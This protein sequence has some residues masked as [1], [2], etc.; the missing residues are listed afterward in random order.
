MPA[1]AGGA[2]VVLDDNVDSWAARMRILESAQ[3]SI[4]VQYFIVEPDAF[5]LSLLGLLAEKARAGVQVRLMVDARGTAGLL[6]G[7]QRYLLQEVAR[8]GADVRVYNPILFQ[9]AATVA[10]NDLRGV[11]ASNHD[12]LVIVDQR[13][14]I[15]GGR[16]LSKD[17][18]SD[19][20]DQPS[21]FTDMD[22]LYD[23]PTTARRL[24]EAFSTEF[25]AKRTT[26]LLIE[27]PG[28]GRTALAL[29]L[30]AMR[31]WVADAPFSAVELAGLDD[32]GKIGLGDALEARVVGVQ[33]QAP[34]G[35]VRDVL[36]D[37]AD[38][39]GARPHLRGAGRRALPAAVE[40]V[41]IRVL[42]THSVEGAVLKNTVNENL[43]VAV[44]GA[45]RSIVIQSPYFVL[46]DRG[47]RAL[48]AAA[49]RGVAITVLT[50]SPA[51]SDSPPTQAAFLRQW[52]EILD[53]IP[54]ARLFVVAEARLMHAKVG[55]IDDELS[56]VGS[57]NLDPLSA[58]VNGEVVG[59][60]WSPG[61][62]TRLVGLIRQRIERGAPG[63]VEYRIERDATGTVV[64]KDGAPVVAYGPD[65]HCTTEQLDA[66]RRLEPLL[67]L[68][69]PIL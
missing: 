9:L 25:K 69:A 42:D 58:G 66:V 14:A 45:Q 38:Q 23:S 67:D 21:A 2:V 13:L 12:K 28:D 1:A 20:L 47:M 19:P 53:R 4:D 61:V 62:A 22:V 34:L 51:S 3:R 33:P 41:D 8:A 16:N 63:V 52:P 37:V 48:E 40:D 65:D 68:F 31:A 15:S 46:T 26:P 27:A 17:Y 44:Q 49:A 64:R 55:I 39:L 30:A 36:R 43:L 5:G 35:A 11:T 56:F 60:L 50:N 54:T 32:A 57:Y 59:A 6:R 24:T 7:S 10:R 29:A 18:L